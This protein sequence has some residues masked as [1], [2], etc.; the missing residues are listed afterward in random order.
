VCLVVKW[1]NQHHWRRQQ[2]E[3]AQDFLTQYQQ[4]VASVWARFEA[5][6]EVPQVASQA[7]VQHLLAE[8]A[9]AREQ[10]QEL[11]QELSQELARVREQAQG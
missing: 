4:F 2:M 10:V 3:Q 6:A 11:A 7:R 5:Q 8:L 1:L 9:L